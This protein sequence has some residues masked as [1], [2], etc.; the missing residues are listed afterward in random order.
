M[1]GW[2]KKKK[3]LEPERDLG[4]R[5]GQGRLGVSSFSHPHALGLSLKFG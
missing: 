4:D 3:G 1:T 2:A 5:R